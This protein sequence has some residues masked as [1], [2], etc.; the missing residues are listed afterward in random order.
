MPLPVSVPAITSIVPFLAARHCAVSLAACEGRGKG[1]GLS[2][3]ALGLR[4]NVHG[5]F[6]GAALRTTHPLG[7]VDE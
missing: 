2:A 3:V 4:P 5:A 7:H 1:L 6:P